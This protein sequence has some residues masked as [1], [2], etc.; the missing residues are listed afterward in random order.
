MSKEKREMK[1]KYLPEEFNVDTVNWQK[2]DG[3]KDRWSIYKRTEIVLGAWDYIGFLFKKTYNKSLDQQP[4]EVRPAPEYETNKGWFI[5][6][7]DI[8]E[9]YQWVRDTMRLENK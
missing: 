7:E 2:I 3:V 6:S 9:V 1:L 8:D 5:E 4:R